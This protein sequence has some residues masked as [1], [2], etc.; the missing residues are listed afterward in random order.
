VPT[1]RQVPTGR[2][3][4]RK[5]AGTGKMHMRPELHNWADLASVLTFF[6]TFIGAAVGVFGYIK[7]Q[8]DVSQKGKRLEEFLRSEKMKAV[9]QGQ[10]S[11]IRIIKEVGL[12]E[13][14]IIQASFR[15]PRIRRRVVSDE[16]GLA[17]ELLFE[18]VDEK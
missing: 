14:E 8:C 16:R 2:L 10:R 12:T 13:D 4:A 5:S 9:D 11:V 1:Y 17:Q 6:I 15:N 3:F 7:Y 18:Y